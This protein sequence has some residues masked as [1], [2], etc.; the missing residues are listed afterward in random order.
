M[1]GFVVVD[2]TDDLDEHLRE[3]F[4]CSI[5]YK[6]HEFEYMRDPEKWIYRYK[7]ADDYITKIVLDNGKPIASLGVI[8][9][10]CIVSGKE[11]NVGCFVDDCILPEY[12][13][14]YEDIFKELFVD[15]EKDAKKHGIDVLCGWDYLHLLKKH[16]SFYK[17]L[18]F[19]WVDGVNWFPG[20]SDINE[21]Y[22]HPL[23][24]LI[25]WYWRWAIGLYKYY[26]K[27]IELRLP[28]LNDDIKIRW[29]ENSD[30]PSVVEFINTQEDDA[31]F[32][33][34][35]SVTEY[36]IILEKNNIHGIL[37]EKNSELIGVLTYVVSAWGGW[38][39]G[40]PFYDKKWGIF[41]SYTPDE[42]AVKSKYQKTIVPAHMVLKLMK[43]KDPERKIQNL[44]D[45][46]LMVDIFDKRLDWRRGALFKVGCSEPEFDYGVILAKS[47]RDDIILDKSK[48]WDLPARYII[49]PVPSP[50]Q[51]D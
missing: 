7:L 33:S 47:L 11:V 34:R 24:Y 42:F 41:Y 36:Q 51:S 39:F 20:G 44:N 16:E 12:I 10:R 28:R 49:A 31:E 26:F 1:L 17:Q 35:Y 4:D 14:K 18:G 25:P 9:R 13:G 45:Y 40:K 50:N 37:A 46:S 29:M 32:K 6:R 15:I 48:S 3:L 8:K 38:M 30:I 23:T 43:T 19:S 27:F 2:Y 5:F 21:T 22:P